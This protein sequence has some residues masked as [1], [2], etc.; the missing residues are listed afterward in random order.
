MD[1]VILMV[2]DTRQAAQEIE[3]KEI[4]LKEKVNIESRVQRR[5]FSAILI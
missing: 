5:N 1:D 4:K 3:F 2:I